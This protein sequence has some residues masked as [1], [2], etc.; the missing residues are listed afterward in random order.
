MIIYNETFVVDND[1]V[2]EW[3]AWVKENHIPAVIATGA[4]D[5]HQILEVL[6]SPNEGVTFCIQYFTNAVNRYEDFMLYHLNP[7]HI[8]HNQQFENK[9]VVFNTLMRHID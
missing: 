7:I 1:I 3:L 5:S 2:E 4:F 6:N 8:K 9:F